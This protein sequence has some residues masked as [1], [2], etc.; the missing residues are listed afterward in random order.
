MNC[1]KPPVGSWLGTPNHRFNLHFERDSVLNPLSG[2]TSN[3]LDFLHLNLQNCVERGEVFKKI[4]MTL[5]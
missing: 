5:L 2:Y 1:S 4:E 3:T